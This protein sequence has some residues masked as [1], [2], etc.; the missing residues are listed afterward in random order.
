MIQGMLVSEIKV[1]YSQGHQMTKYSQIKIWL[2]QKGQILE[3]LL[4]PFVKTL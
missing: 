2:P 4:N 1:S 3:E